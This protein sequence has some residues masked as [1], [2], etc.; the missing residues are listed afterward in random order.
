MF[1]MGIVPPNGDEHDD[2]GRVQKPGLSLVV[3]GGYLEVLCARWRFF[4]CLENP[5]LS[6][7]LSS[8]TVTLFSY[9]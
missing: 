3:A 1:A 4:F 5:I 6:G 9:G 2:S 8:K 7:L